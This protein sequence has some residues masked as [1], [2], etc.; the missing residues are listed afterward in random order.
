MEIPMPKTPGTHAD[1]DHSQQPRQGIEPTR[2]ERSS[3]ADEDHAAER[4]KL[5]DK[6][7]SADK[8]GDASKTRSPTHGG[9]R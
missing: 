7:Q 6:K 9:T 1:D 8:E 4:E 5:I 2:R 3:I